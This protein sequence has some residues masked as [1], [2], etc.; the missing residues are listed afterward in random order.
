MVCADGL[1]STHSELI[2]W[3]GL[4]L[5]RTVSAKQLYRP[6]HADPYIPFSFDLC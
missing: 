6:Y 3:L 1:G 5:L 4:G 2:P